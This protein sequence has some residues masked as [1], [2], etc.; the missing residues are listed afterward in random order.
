MSVLLTLSLY[1]M[2]IVFDPPNSGLFSEVY[3]YEELMEADLHAIVRLS[4]SD[5]SVVG[6]RAKGL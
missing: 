1:D 6:R 2:D 5:S 4:L 3:L